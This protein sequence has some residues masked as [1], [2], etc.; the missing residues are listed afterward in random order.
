MELERISRDDPAR[1]LT[2]AEVA[3]LLSVPT[4]WVYAQS[5]A[6]RIP[7]VACGRYRRGVVEACLAELE[8][9]AC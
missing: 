2:A 1:L 6:G 3:R 7:T 5:R 8:T 4:S 9:R